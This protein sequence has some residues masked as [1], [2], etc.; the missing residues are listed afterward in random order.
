MTSPHLIS[1]APPA[2]VTIKKGTL[3]D[4]DFCADSRGSVHP[5]LISA[6]ISVYQRAIPTI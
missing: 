3:M 1:I 5:I 4:A 2:I 6:K